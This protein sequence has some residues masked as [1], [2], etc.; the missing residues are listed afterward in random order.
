MSF[1]ALSVPSDR[2]A[3]RNGALTRAALACR[4][5]GA[6]P[7]IVARPRLA[8]PPRRTVTGLGWQ[9]TYGLVFPR[10]AGSKRW[11]RTGA[12]LGGDAG[13]VRGD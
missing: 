11:L 1:R 9:G 10:V 4:R 3:S 6:L 5:P 2:L 7:A 12:V 8:G 13:N